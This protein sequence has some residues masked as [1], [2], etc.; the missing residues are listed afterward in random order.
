[1]A[2]VEVTCPYPDCTT[3]TTASIPDDSEFNKEVQSYE[4]GIRGD[5]N[6]T[7]VMC[8]GGHTFGVKYN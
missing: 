6:L 5:D 7:E 1:M 8:S 4:N 3:E 2:T